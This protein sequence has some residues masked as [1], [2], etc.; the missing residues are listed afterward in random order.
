MEDGK[1]DL[2]GSASEKDIQEGRFQFYPERHCQPYS[3]ELWE[4]CMKWLTKRDL[5][6]AEYEEL[7]KK[8]VKP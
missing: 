4:A 3:P 6:K 5:L 2:Q 8:G 7:M 1:I